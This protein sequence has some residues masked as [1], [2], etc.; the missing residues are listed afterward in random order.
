MNNNNVPFIL[1]ELDKL[2]PDAKP[3]LHY[4]TPF[5]LLVATILSAQCTDRQVNK[6]TAV[7]FADHNTPEAISKLSEETLAS[8][9]KSCG[10]YN[11]K[12]KNIIKTA[13]II[14]NEYSGEV[15]RTMEELIKLP[16]VGRKTANVVLSNAFNIPALAVDTHVARVSVRIGLADGEDVLKIERRLMEV[17]PKD[18]WSIA[19]HWLIFHGRRVCIAKKPRCFE[20]TLRCFCRY[21]Q[22]KES[23]K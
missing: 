9:V 16:G 14:C 21:Y 19:H 10:F 22:E 3:E 17:I 7:L 11:T 8:Y 4:S 5:E 23:E 20:C 1:D 13:T 6:C 18:K 15:P 2:H 12:V